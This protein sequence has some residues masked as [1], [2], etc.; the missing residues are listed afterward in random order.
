MVVEVARLNHSITGHQMWK[1]VQ[2]LEF[3]KKNFKVTRQECEIDKSLFEALYSA[4]IRVTLN[5]RASGDGAS[6]PHLMFY[7]EPGHSGR[8]KEK[9]TAGFVSDLSKISQQ[10]IKIVEATPDHRKALIDECRTMAKELVEA[11]P[12]EYEK[13]RDKDVHPTD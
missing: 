10:L 7:V 11:P 1:G 5:T 12:D 6:Q 9:A 2:P 8:T 13:F 4:W 3:Y